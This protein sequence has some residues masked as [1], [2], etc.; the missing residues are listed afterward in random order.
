MTYRALLIDDEPDCL[1]LLSWQIENFCP[2]LEIV[3]RCGSAME[4]LPAIE[5][6]RPEV[7]FLDIQ[8][9]V[10]DGFQLLENLT[11]WD[12]EVIFTT[13]F[14]RYA[15]K[16]I[17]CS[18]LD[19][20]LKPIVKAE[21]LEAVKKLTSR[22]KPDKASRTSSMETLFQN[23]KS[24]LKQKITVH[25]RETVEF[26]EVSQILFLHA[27][28]NY[29]YIYL[30]GGRKILASK[31]LKYFEEILEE[32]MFFRVHAS[33]LINVG[34]IVCFRKTDG[35]TVVLSDSSEIPVARTRKEQFLK[36]M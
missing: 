1:S 4:G 9:P 3:A 26:V 31:T 19:Y 11:E 14:D 23:L 6:F 35:G 32:P 16:A 24:P 2:E 29:T 28:S 12:F 30:K 25:S 33:Y 15:L 21:L 5:K 36:L 8:M 7:L 20:L 17:K 22:K 34:E 13:A 27:E 18:A 10:M